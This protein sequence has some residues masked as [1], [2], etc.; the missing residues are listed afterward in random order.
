MAEATHLRLALAQI[1]TTVGDIEGNV[2][3][4]SESI[5]RA[6]DAGAQLVLLPEL[7]ISG[8]P[9]EDL[10]LR[11]DFLDAVRGGLEEIASGTEG[12]VAL[13]GFP[14][15]RERPR[16]ELERFDPSIDP[17]PPP[18]YNSLAVVGGGEVRAV[19]RK[20][21]L[22]N[23]GVFDE[24]RY[25]EPGTEPA[26]IEVDGVLVGL[27]VCEDIWHPGFPEA[28]EAAAGARLVVNSSASPYHRGKGRAREAMVADRA[29]GND[30]AFALCN[31]VG[32]QDE[33][34][35]D[36]AS[37]VTGPDG[38]TLA[39]AAQFEEE[40]LVCDLMVPARAVA[41]G[42]SSARAP[43]LAKLAS[44][45]E[46]GGHLE[47]R[48]ADPIASEEAEV[49]TALVLG[50]RDYVGKNGFEHVVLA[51][52]GGID[53]ALVALIAVDA[54]GPER[55]TAVSMPSPYSSQGTRSDAQAIAARLGIEL[56]EISIAE[57]MAAYGRA[58]EPAFGGT[59]PGIAEEN[60]Q[61][62]IRGNLVMALSNKFG[63]LVLTTGNKSEMSVGYATLYGDMAGGFAVIKDI[64]K[65]LV[66]RLVS[67]RNETEG[68]ELIPASVLER[69][70]SAE[71]RPDQLDED[72]LP[73]YET[74]DRILEGY[75]ERDEGVEAL[76]AQ[77]LDEEA[78]REVVRLVD[79]AEYKRRQAPPGIRVSTK[80]F[81]RDRRLPITNR[82]GSMRPLPR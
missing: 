19:Y 80:A 77:G 2:R 26:L 70:P 25:F 68:R 44:G 54:L 27:T 78:V 8:Y 32:G 66:Y 3:L 57:A 51:L 17:L 56:L 31:A 63:W 64:F 58:L 75:V 34:V 37:V 23:Y 7:C 28:E 5:E 12:I 9:P 4:I 11:R 16:E 60:L 10:V 33:L 47:P 59:E 73:P 38:G 29:R 48:F 50:L 39:R 69:A 42:A 35:F 15:L 40:L 67:W 14:E 62:R 52:S 43:L 61:A 24:R 45:A 71:L 36:G 18:A 49:Y 6:Q 53:S 82:F 76:V 74:L 65:Q 72:S 55:V 46:P 81:G 41:D 79:R 20:C 22:P 13:V 30:A 21:D 1:D